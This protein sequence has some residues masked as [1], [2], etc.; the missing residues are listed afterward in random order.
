MD[1]ISVIV[2]VYK[3]EQY[4]DK[5][6][7]SI[8]DQTYRNLEIILVDDGS[9]DSCGAMCDAWAEKDSRIK[10]IHKENGGLS[11]A[12]NAGMAA[13]SGKYMGFVDSDDCITPDMYQL[14]LE[15]MVSDG[16]DIA[17]CGV[18]MVY[19][20]GSPGQMLTASGSWVLDREEA[21]E[22]IVRESLLKQPVWYKLYRAE[23]IQDIPFAV[24]KY[25]EDV[26]WTWQA[27]DRAEKI[28]VFDTPCYYYLQRSGSIMGERFSEKRLDAVEANCIRVEY[29]LKHY[30]RIAQLD[31]CGLHFI[32]LYFGQQAMRTLDKAQWE[33]ILE[34]LSAAVDRYPVPYRVRR[35]LN[36]S[37]RLWLWMIRHS[38]VSTCRIRNMLRLGM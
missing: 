7:Q 27:I 2:P 1:L 25:H 11:D 24:G 38:F 34:A 36:Q 6:V 37:H 32:C 35:A 17:A 33:P 19:E 12:R 21:M 28:S 20:N 31:L 5:C 10:V 8:V 22:A 23:L 9:P 18:E 30:P 29:L 14:L 16:S 26:F 13:A 4:L 15:R 3:V